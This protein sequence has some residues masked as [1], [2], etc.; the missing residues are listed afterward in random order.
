[1]L[2]YTKSLI[3]VILLQHP[4][5]RNT[6]PCMQPSILP[7][8]YTFK[9]AQNEPNFVDWIL[10]IMEGKVCW[11]AET[12]GIRCTIINQIGPPRNSHH[13]AQFV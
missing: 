5:I 12:A 9:V 2:S 10:N 8:G 11:T 4:G 3:S 1:M 6:S 7:Y 13:T